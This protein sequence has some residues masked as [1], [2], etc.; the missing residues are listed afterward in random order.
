MHPACQG[1]SVGA[2]LHLASCAEL[3]KKPV[4]GFS[5]GLVD[6]RCGQSSG[7]QLG[8]NGTGRGRA[9]QRAA[10]WHLHWLAPVSTLI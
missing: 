9:G 5:A 6:D 8:A 4:E 2:V 10:C 7:C 1:T 3:T